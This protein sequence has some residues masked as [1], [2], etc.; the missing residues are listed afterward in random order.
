MAQIKSSKI[1]VMG[2]M[3]VGKTSILTRYIKGSF[4]QFNESTIG[5][6]FLSKKDK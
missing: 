3:S 2:D 4:D 1:V 5:A 6:A